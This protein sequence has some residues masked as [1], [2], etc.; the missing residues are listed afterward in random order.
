MS[1]YTTELRWPLEQ[2]F[3]DTHPDYY[4]YPEPYTVC[5]EARDII[6]DFYYP[7][8]PEDKE[9]FEIN[10]LLHYYTREIGSETLGLFK[11]RLQSRLNEIIPK[12]NNLWNQLA[13]MARINIYDNVD[14]TT[15]RQYDSDMT[16]TGNT[17]HEFDNFR[18]TTTTRKTGTDTDTTTYSGSENRDS[19][20]TE[21][22][23]DTPMGTIDNMTSVH[24]NMYLSA[25]KITDT[26]A[27]TTFNN[28]KDTDVTQYNSSTTSTRTPTGKE[29]EVYNDIKDKHNGTDTE[30]VKGK[31]GGKS[32]SE[33][34]LKARQLFINVDQML[35]KDLQNLFMLIW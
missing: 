5:I 17:S 30:T 19:T 13:Q 8:N 12:Y 18:D 14:L 3:N 22:V 28:R 29:K 35:I 10:F 26:V 23:S 27:P 33:E 7:I 15:I 4:G 2:R 20:V 11:L 31:N 21:R 16:R 32:Y 24:N 34:M 1:K 25:A 9:R 6:F